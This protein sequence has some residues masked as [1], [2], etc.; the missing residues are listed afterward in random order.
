MLQLGKALAVS[1]CCEL[2]GD[3]FSVRIPR[4]LQGV[5]RFCAFF[6]WFFCGENVVS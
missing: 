1:S 2:C 5:A 3:Y 6:G 4:F